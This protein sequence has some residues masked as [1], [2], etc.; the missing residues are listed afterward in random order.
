[1]I[2]TGIMSVP[3]SGKPTYFNITFSS[4]N[5][6]PY[7]KISILLTPT[8][9]ALTSTSI[10]INP[11]TVGSLSSVFL[12]FTT[13]NNQILNPIGISFTTPLTMSL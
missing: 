13:T 3:T 7:M 4:N 1:M 12:S 9:R 8:P 2:F 10:S 6:K 5:N 11:N